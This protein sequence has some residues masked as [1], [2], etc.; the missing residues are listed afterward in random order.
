MNKKE[1]QLDDLTHVINHWEWVVMTGKSKWRYDLAQKWI[2]HC[3]LCNKYERSMTVNCNR[4]VIKIHTYRDYGCQY[5]TPYSR[6]Y[7][8][9]EPCARQKAAEAF[10]AYLY[11][12]YNKIERDGAI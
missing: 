6:Y 10:L 2:N 9:V 11:S 5:N 1:I 4:C 7:D 3:Y 12:L 8:T